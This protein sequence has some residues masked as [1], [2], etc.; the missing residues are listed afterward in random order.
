MGGMTGCSGDD[1]GDPS[2][3]E[4]SSLRLFGDVSSRSHG[5]LDQ[6]KYKQLGEIVKALFMGLTTEG[7]A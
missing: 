7:C 1:P 6:E 2:S 4:Q 5:R 3:M